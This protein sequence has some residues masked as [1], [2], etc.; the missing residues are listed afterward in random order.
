MDI[1]A[2]VVSIVSLLV[3]TS[4]GVY[5]LIQ[6]KN[7]NRMSLES[8]YF[9]ELFKK[10]LLVDLPKS[11]KKITFDANYVLVNTDELTK[12]LNDLRHNALYFQYTDKEFYS[13]LKNAL[14]ALEDYVV[15]SENVEMIGE[16]QSEFYNKMQELITDIYDVLLQKHLNG[17]VNNH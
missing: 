5:E 16:D 15:L 10:F 2:L 17:K 1:I 8:E 14:R 3:S 13:K 6:N 11:R 4:L 9:D 12:S 7:L